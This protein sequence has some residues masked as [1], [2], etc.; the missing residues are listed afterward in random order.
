MKE[1][2]KCRERVRVRE[3]TSIDRN[4]HIVYKVNG[5]S[6]YPHVT[7]IYKTHT[8]TRFIHDPI[9]HACVCAGG[10]GSVLKNINSKENSFPRAS[11]K[12]P[13]PLPLPSAIEYKS[14][15]PKSYFI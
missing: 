8:H 15:Q 1:R 10:W 5:N 12:C 4:Y 9:K 2:E 3:R 11:L 13:L 7:D 14:F 6:K